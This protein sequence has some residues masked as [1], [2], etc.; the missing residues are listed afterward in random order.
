MAKSTHVRI[1]V[2][3][4]KELKSKIG[5]FNKNKKAKTTVREFIEKSV[6][7]SLARLP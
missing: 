3:M 7:K 5:T 4:Y 2:D 1:N 6:R